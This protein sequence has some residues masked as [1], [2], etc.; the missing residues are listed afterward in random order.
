MVEFWNERYKESDYAYGERPNEFFKNQL[1]KLSPGKILLPADGEGRNA[2]FAA[3]KGWE[4]VAF[5]QSISGKEKA[6]QLADKEN[7]IIDFQI[8]DLNHFNYPEESFD[9]VAMIYVHM[10]KEMRTKVHQKLCSLLK[11]GGTLI[12]EGF[13]KEHLAY[14]AK[15]PQAGGPKAID[16][17]FSHEE[18]TADFCDLKIE[19]LEETITHLNEGNYHVGESA[20]IRM[21][22][23]KI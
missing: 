21:I 2:V 14:S 18:L 20:V 6:L 1:E 17:L 15:N 10:P 5:D 9:A 22:A 7:V 23:K 8:D 16:L 4:V 12:L 13:S 11:P 3:K 19:F